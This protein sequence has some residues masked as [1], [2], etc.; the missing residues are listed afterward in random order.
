MSKQQRK[1]VIRVDMNDKFN[2]KYFKLRNLG[3]DAREELKL[4]VPNLYIP[5]YDDL[6]KPT[7]IVIHAYKIS[8]DDECRC[9]FANRWIAWARKETGADWE[10]N[11]N[12]V[13]EK[14]AEDSEYGFLLFDNSTKKIKLIKSNFT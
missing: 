1:Y 10:M 4:D 8:N 9:A 11:K 5:F 6:S 2:M 7:N 3:E 13:V 14:G 12:I